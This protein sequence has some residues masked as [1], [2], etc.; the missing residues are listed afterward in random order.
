MSK[1]KNVEKKIR[2][3]ERFDAAFH[4]NGKDVHGAREGIPQYPYSRAAKKDMTVNE[5]KQER[6][7]KS[8]P[9]YDVV[10]YDG[11]GDAVFGQTKISTVRDTYP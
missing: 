3:V 6:F 10:V 1:V 8:Y 4:Q 9:G 5:W 2:D 7:G 11:N